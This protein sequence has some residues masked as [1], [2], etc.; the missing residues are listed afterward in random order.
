[1]ANINVFTTFGKLQG[2][3]LWARASRACCTTDFSREL[4]DRLVVV[5]DYM[6]ANLRSDIGS[7]VITM[8]HTRIPYPNLALGE[9]GGAFSEE[10]LNNRAISLLDPIDTFVADHEG[11]VRQA[12]LHHIS[13][14]RPELEGLGKIIDELEREV[15]VL[16]VVARLSHKGNVVN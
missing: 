14:P 11:L 5:L 3:K 15:G 8:R 6:I 10:W 12:A 16:F 1:M 4:H 9:S 13:V 7:E 2:F